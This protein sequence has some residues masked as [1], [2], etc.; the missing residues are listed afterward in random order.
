MKRILFLLCA[1]LL[2]KDLADDGCL[3]KATALPPH[4]PGKF[5]FTTSPDSSGTIVAQVWLSPGELR[6]IL[7]RWPNQPVVIEV[8]NTLAKIDSYLLSSSGGLPL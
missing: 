2:L 8:G 1:L 3:C 7:Q 4:G 5:S 6:G